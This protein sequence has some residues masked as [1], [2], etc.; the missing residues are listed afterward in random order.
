VQHTLGQN[1]FSHIAIDLD[2]FGM[3]TFGHHTI[4]ATDFGPTDIW[5][6]QINVF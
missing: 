4:E 3:N 2:T 1:T 6:T 5:P